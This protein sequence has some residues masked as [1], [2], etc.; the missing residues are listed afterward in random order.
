MAHNKN[1]KTNAIVN[2]I[3]YSRD[4]KPQIIL[5]FKYKIYKILKYFCNSH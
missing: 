3:A 1:L 5:T 2:C 4:A